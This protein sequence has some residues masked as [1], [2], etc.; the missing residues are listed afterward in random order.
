MLTARRD[1][2]YWDYNSEE[3]MKLMSNIEKAVEKVKNLERRV[4]IEEGVLV[5]MAKKLGECG[6]F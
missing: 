1:D 3:Y 4:R 5:A 6:R 2:E